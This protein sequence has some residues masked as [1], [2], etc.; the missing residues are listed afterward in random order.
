MKPKALI[1]EPTR[2]YQG[3]A[4]KL[5]DDIGVDCRIFSSSKDALE[6]QH[7][8]YTI[9]LISRVL[10]DISGEIF[11]SLYS[12]KHG[13]GIATCI[14]LTSNDEQQVLQEATKVG[15]QFVFNK[16][17]LKPLQ[18]TIA[19]VVNNNTLDLAANILYI[20]DSKSVAGAT[21]ELFKNKN[22]RIQHVSD[23]DSMQSAF[24]EHSFDLVITDYYLKNDETGDDVISFVREYDDQDRSNTPILVVSSESNHEKRLL[25]LRNGAN[26]FIIKPY[27]NNEL[28][29]RASNLIK[30]H[31]LLSESKEQR[32]ALMKLALTDHLTGLYNRHS[33]YDIGPRYISNAHR[34]NIPL[35][36]LVIDLD[37]FKRINDT[38]GHA[39]GDLVLQSIANLLVTSCRTEDIAARFGGEE[40]IMLL[41]NS[42]IEDAAKKAEALRSL[43]AE[44]KPQGIDVTTSIGISELIEGDDFDSLFERADQAVYSSKE[45]GRNRVS[46]QKAA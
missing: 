2:L 42:N 28:L 7:D 32:Q 39:T 4:Q 23:I 12:I 46:L 38:K 20:E 26:D 13:L 31:K 16:N 9:I 11:L 43:I 36:L 14:L 37:Y 3:I 41:V 45:N 24:C 8:E 15:Y 5:M 19:D 35:S 1:V 34:H 6:S 18:D 27:D 22:S 29:V 44:T 33:L 21:V 25:L 17:N 10:D 40:F 30:N